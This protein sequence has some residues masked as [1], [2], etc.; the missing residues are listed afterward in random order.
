MVSGRQTRQPGW[1]TSSST[2]P[3]MI[4]EVIKMLPNLEIHDS[5]ILGELYNIRVDPDTRRYISV[6]QDD[7]HDSH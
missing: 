6:G 1:L 3:A 7:L 5:R 2:K 4:K